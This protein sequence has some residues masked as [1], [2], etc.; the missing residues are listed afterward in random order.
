MKYG[1]LCCSTLEHRLVAIHDAEK[2]LDFLRSSF[3]TKMCNV[4]MLEFTMRSPRQFACFREIAG[5]IERF[6]LSIL[7][8]PK[9]LHLD[10]EDVF[11]GI[12][13]QM[14]MLCS[15]SEIE[16]HLKS[17][18]CRDELYINVLS[19]HLRYSTLLQGCNI[20]HLLMARY[21][22]GYLDSKSAVHLF[23]S[24]FLEELVLLLRSNRQHVLFCA[25]EGLF[26]VLLA[27]KKTVKKIL[28]ILFSIEVGFGFEISKIL[29]QYAANGLLEMEPCDCTASFSGSQDCASKC[30]TIVYQVLCE[31]D[32]NLTGKYGYFCEI[33]CE[34]IF[35]NPLNFFVFCGVLCEFF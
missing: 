32:S 21:V 8:P 29:R 14:F 11:L 2:Y 24:N 16:A 5:Q 28:K 17:V 3:T 12:V 7:H 30:M 20:I 25:L 31:L 34:K 33:E 27:K 18:I 26:P 22:S 6:G 19:S 9:Q 10:D 35:F 15:D 4:P 23:N 13:S 1:F